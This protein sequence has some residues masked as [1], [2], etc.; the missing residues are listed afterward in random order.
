[1]SKKYVE[2]LTSRKWMLTVAVCF[3]LGWFHEWSELVQVTIGFLAVQGGI[4]A[5]MSTRSET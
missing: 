5:F 2:R 1:M 4:D 3:T